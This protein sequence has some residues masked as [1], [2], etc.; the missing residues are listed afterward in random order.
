MPKKKSLWTTVE[1]TLEI[2]GWSEPPTSMKSSVK[3][4]PGLY[5]IM[6]SAGKWKLQFRKR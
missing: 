5:R 6:R 4:N 3:Q 2:P 1:K